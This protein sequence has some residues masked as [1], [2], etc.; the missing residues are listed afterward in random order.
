MKEIKF[1]IKRGGNIKGGF[2]QELEKEVERKVAIEKGFLQLTVTNAIDPSN[3]IN[4]EVRNEETINARAVFSTNS[5]KRYRIHWEL[6]DLD[7][8]ETVS[9]IDDEQ[10]LTGEKIGKDEINLRPQTKTRSTNYR[11]ICKVQVLDEYG[12]LI[13]PLESSIEIK[14][15]VE[16]REE[17]EEESFISK[18]SIVRLETLKS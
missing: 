3:H 12:D 6:L 8:K 16:P 4:A 14:V 18:A 5:G 1:N 15:L 11:I 13:L 17:P 9:D 7:T 2:V 10:L